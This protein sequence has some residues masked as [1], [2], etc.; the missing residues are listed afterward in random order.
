MVMALPGYAFSRAA[1]MLMGNGFG[2][3]VG[4]RVGVSVAVFIAVDVEVLQPVALAVASGVELIVIFAGAGELVLDTFSW[5][6]ASLHPASTTIRMTPRD[7]PEIIL[8][9]FIFKPICEV[10]WSDMICRRI[11]YSSG[12]QI[13]HRLIFLSHASIF[14]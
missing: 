3:L 11:L 5:L 1:S 2:V 9:S 6:R 12:G 7:I 4:S 10:L 8:V 13:I 14:V